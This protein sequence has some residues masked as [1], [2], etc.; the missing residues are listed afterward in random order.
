MRS[1]PKRGSGASSISL[2][3]A[4]HSNIRTPV[5]QE[6][7]DS[8]IGPAITPISLISLM[9]PLVAQKYFARY[10]RRV[11]LRAT[12]ALGFVVFAPPRRSLGVL[13]LR[14]RK[15]HLVL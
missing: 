10:K 14:F 3:A 7:A 6:Q 8:F 9:F 4:W 15:V 5:H 1:V 13:V 11:L 2:V 12:L